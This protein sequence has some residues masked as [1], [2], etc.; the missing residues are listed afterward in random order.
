[1]EAASQ[2]SGEL[3]GEALKSVWWIH[4]LG[5]AAC[6]CAGGMLPSGDCKPTNPP[7]DAG[8]PDAG[9]SAGTGGTGGSTRLTREQLMDPDACKDCHPKHYEEWSGSMHAYAADDP[10]FIAMNKRGQRETNGQLGDFCVKCH[11]P[12]AVRTGATTDGLNLA[13]VPQKLKGV[14]C[15]FC[16]TVNGVEQGHQSNNPLTLANDDVMRGPF[17]DP[18]VSSAHYAGYSVFLHRDRIESA[19]LC[20]TCHDIVN[21]HG[22][23]IERTFAEWKESVFSQ[24]IVGTTCGQCHMDQTVQLEPVA[25]VANV[26]PRRRHSHL[27]AAVDNAVTPFP[28]EASVQ[29]LVAANQ[30]LLNTTL[31]SVLC[32]RGFPGQ[33]SLF[34]VLD[35]AASGHAF[36][37]GASQDRRLWV[38]IEAFSGGQ[39]IYS[40]GVLQNDRQPVTDLLATDP[41]LWIMRDRLFDDQGHEVHNFWDATCY[42]SLQLPARQTFSISDPRFYQSH[43]MKTYPNGVGGRFFLAAYPDRVRMRVRLSPI[44]QDVLQD[45]IDSGDLSDLRARDNAVVY[46]VGVPLEWT[47]A[48]VTETFVDQQGIPVSC[49]SKTNLRGADPKTLAA[50]RSTCATPANAFR[51]NGDAP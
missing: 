4:L 14:T 21:G 18:Y 51:V 27:F 34:V 16:H 29:R 38:E 44:G 50:P 5:L 3:K 20:G 7:V 13:D 33:A 30:A 9:G 32:V 42:D 15:F 40:S 28:D 19:T 11:A 8:T 6:A 10:V 12:M 2:P 43:V 45:L 46:D 49:I 22:T 39:R 23:H 25:N 35:N 24:Q 1:V 31:Q 41:D 17:N 26:P 47:A 36:P 48:T 37:S